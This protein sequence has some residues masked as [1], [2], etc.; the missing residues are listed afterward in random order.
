MLKAKGSVKIGIAGA[1]AGG[2]E[3]TLAAQFALGRMLEAQKAE[4][5][6]EF[7]LFS[8]T[9]ILPTHNHKARA[10]FRRVLAE[11]GVHV[12]AGK[13]VVEV[14]VSSLCC[15]DGSEFTLDEILWVTQAGAAFWPGKSGLEVDARGFIRLADTL[16]STSHPG[17]FASG[18]IA[19][20]VNH[21]R[22]KAGVFAV[23][24]EKPLDGNLR[25]SLLGRPLKPFVPQRKFLSLIRVTPC[26]LKALASTRFCSLLSHYG[27]IDSADCGYDVIGVSPGELRIQ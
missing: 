20:V 3:L 8:G 9:D 7:Y 22:E 26:W 24:Q 13:S 25:Y 1:G 16:E 5:V 12:H 15:E 18:D 19:S 2:V 21:P 17:V 6:L 23:R 27:R 11:R 14:G 4:A 10:K